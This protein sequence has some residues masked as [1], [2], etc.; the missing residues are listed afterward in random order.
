MVGGLWQLSTASATTT[1]TGIVAGLILL[2]VAAGLTIPS[3]TESVMGSLPSAHT[4]V[5]SATNAAF[6]QVGGAPTVVEPIVPGETGLSDPA[7]PLC[8][9]P[10]TGRRMT[11]GPARPRPRD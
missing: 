8:A 5:G 2:G 9:G 3:A 10:G 7:R 11:S 4:G 6:L 1:F